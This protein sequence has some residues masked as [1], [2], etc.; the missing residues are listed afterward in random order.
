M[1]MPDKTKSTPS[2]FESFKE[3]HL[4]GYEKQRGDTYKKDLSDHQHVNVKTKGNT[5]TMA[6]FEPTSATKY[7]D[8]MTD[9]MFEVHRS[10][11]NVSTPAGPGLNGAGAIANLGCYAEDSSVSIKLTGINPGLL[12]TSP[13]SDLGIGHFAV[14]L[15]ARP[16]SADELATMQKYE[17]RKEVQFQEDKAAAKAAEERRKRETK[18]A[19]SICQTVWANC[20]AASGRDF[21]AKCVNYYISCAFSRLR[22]SDYEQICDVPY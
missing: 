8:G 3:K 22:S 4:A 6:L 21:D 20:M 2:D 7:V 19:C 11:T 18:S 1:L 5:C 16:A 9:I 13:S 15:Y 10:G 12:G 17:Q 14:S